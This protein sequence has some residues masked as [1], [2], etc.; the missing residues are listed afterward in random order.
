[1]ARGSWYIFQYNVCLP[2]VMC[3]TACLYWHA[4][5]RRWRATGDGRWCATWRKPQRFTPGL[6]SQSPGHR[7]A[8]STRLQVWPLFA[9]VKS[10]PAEA[11]LNKCFAL[12]CRPFTRRTWTTKVLEGVAVL[13]T[14]KWILLCKRS[15]KT[16]SAFPFCLEN[17]SCYFTCNTYWVKYLLCK[18]FIMY[19]LQLF[20]YPL[21]TNGVQYKLSI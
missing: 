18:V 13:R 14:V 5:D 3:Q 21:E 4:G 1:M 6:V 12:L 9:L 2:S 8:H 7:E 16:V 20:F 11:C 15:Q 17:A 10:A 19:W